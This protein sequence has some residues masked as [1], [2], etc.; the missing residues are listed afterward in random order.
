MAKTL[1]EQIADSVEDDMV[2]DGPVVPQDEVPG[3][4]AGMDNG[5]STD[6]DLSA[7][8]PKSHIPDIDDGLS[9]SDGMHGG[10][11]DLDPMGGTEAPASFL[12]TEIDGAT[13]ETP[14]VAPGETNAAPPSPGS[15][16]PAG[17]IKVEPSM[18][19]KML[20]HAKSGGDIHHMASHAA[21]IC[22]DPGC[23]HLGLEHFEE[24]QAAAPM[25]TSE[26]GG[27]GGMDEMD[28]SPTG[29]ADGMPGEEGEPMEGPS[30]EVEI[31]EDA[32]VIGQAASDSVEGPKEGNPFAKGGAE[33]KDKDKGKDKGGTE[34]KAAEDEVE[35]EAEE[36][37]A[38]EAEGDDVAES[39]KPLVD[40]ILEKFQFPKR[41][42]AT[43]N[44]DPVP[45]KGKG[46]KGKKSGKPWEKD[47]DD[48]ESETVAES[49]DRLTRLLSKKTSLVFQSTQANHVAEFQAKPSARFQQVFAESVT[50]AIGN[51]EWLKR[52]DL[53]ALSKYKRASVINTPSMGQRHLLVLE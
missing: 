24:M 45:T 42:Q 10:E 29:V 46:A 1:M 9:G 14:I 48:D 37:T 8:V 27:M 35:E 12:S 32:L 41:Q 30:D 47:G 40:P 16:S 6:E 36:E 23:S 39:V 2:A 5:M 4:E 44:T 38:E 34:D 50:K 49:V 3:A 52:N 7:F 26:M 17:V 11:A 19:I 28:S 25:G 31:P 53:A 51:K 13:D 22:G 15:F 18:L 43:E 20:E 21:K 33:G